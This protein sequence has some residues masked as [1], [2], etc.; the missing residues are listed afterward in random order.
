MRSQVPALGI[1]L[2]ILGLIN[3]LW[4][5]VYAI[6]SLLGVSL[7]HMDNSYYMS[8]SEQIGNLIGSG[9]GML[10]MFVWV[11]GGVLWAAAGFMIRGFKGRGFAIGVIIAGM[12]P[13]CLAHLC[14]TWVFNLGVGIWALIV[15]FNGDTANA[16]AERAA[17][18]TVDE[19]LGRDGFEF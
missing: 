6:L 2:M 18:S 8:E 13:C 19:V 1:V 5:L 11:L 15:L 12:I 10:W 14:C 17:G 3:T 7:D 4:Y 16:F 9:I